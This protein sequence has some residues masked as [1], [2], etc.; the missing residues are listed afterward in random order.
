[1]N[2]KYL[3]GIAL[4]AATAVAACGGG[5]DQ[6]SLGGD[7]S[8]DPGQGG[9]GGGKTGGGSTGGGAAGPSTGQGGPTDPS[10]PTPTNSPTGKDFFIANVYPFL[11]SGCAACHVSGAGGAPK[12]MG[13]DP[14]SSYALQFANGFVITNSAILT[15]PAHGG[16]TTNVLTTAQKDTY[17]KWIAMETAGGGAKAQPNVLDKISGCIDATKLQAIG[18]QNVRTIQ[19]TANNNTN[20]VTPWNE[21][22][23]RCTGCNQ[24]ACRDCHSG[25]AASSFVMAIGNNALPATYTFDQTKLTNPAYLQKYFGTDATGKPVASHAIENKMT[26]VSKGVAYS[27]PYFT[28][29]AAQIAGIDAFVQ[30]AIT[31]YNANTCTPATPPATP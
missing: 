23:N 9:T 30:D 5:A 4:A 18:L 24:A 14:D 21:N 25:D 10:G 28:L 16:S 2:A 13:A 12:W 3:L 20:N 7:D 29:T 8:S 15:K 17:S 27:H 1:M 31:K 22:A 6:N 11:Q 19:R 26:A